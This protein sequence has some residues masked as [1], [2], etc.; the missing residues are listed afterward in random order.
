MTKASDQVQSLKESIINA[1]KAAK[2]VVNE[3]FLV[4]VKK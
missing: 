3:L 4:P 1:N 2:S